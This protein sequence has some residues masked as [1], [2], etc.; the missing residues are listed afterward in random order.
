MSTAKKIQPIQERANVG[1]PQVPSMISPGWDMAFAG[2]LSIAVYL[3]MNVSFRS[4]TPDNSIALWVFNLSFVMNFPHFLSSYQMLYGDFR[5][6]IT[7]N[8]RFFWAAVIVP[9]ILAGGMIAAFAASSPTSLGYFVSAMYFFV[10]W[11]YVKQTFG[12]IVVGNALQK[13]FYNKQE[14][15]WLQANMYS[16]WAVSFFAAN[17][18]P[19]SYQQMGIYYPSFN[20]GML[21]LNI[22]YAALAVSAFGNILS[23]FR[24]YIREGSRPS[25]MAIMGYLTIYIWLLPTLTHSM[26]AHMAPF[27]HSL[28]YLLFVFAFRRNKVE[29]GLKDM[30]PVEA[31]QQRVFGLWGFFAGSIILGAL[32]FQLVPGFLDQLHIVDTTKFGP[33]PMIFFATIFINIH[34][35]FIDNV[36]W[37]GNNPEMRQYLFRAG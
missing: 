33:T 35:Y 19:A 22:A 31:R 17:S 4:M 2:A 21:P 3:L 25:N 18:G 20:F 8:I 24:K 29:A 12:V 5:Q 11:H 37:K 27:F 6:E 16:L 23:H 36:I 10:G 32:A 28:Q 1:T 15:F 7:R 30:P 9:V 34:H 14:R 13:V 26:Y